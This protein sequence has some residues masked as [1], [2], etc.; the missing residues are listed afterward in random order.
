MTEHAHTAESLYQREAFSRYGVSFTPDWREAVKTVVDD[1]LCCA[2]TGP[3]LAVMFVA[4]AWSD[5]YQEIVALVRE[6]TGT[7]CL[8]GCSS[9]GVIGGGS[10]HE[11]APGITLMGMW[12]PGATLHPVRLQDHPDDWPWGDAVQPVD[13]R[14]IMMFTDPYRADAQGTLMGLREQVPGTPIVGSQAST[15]RKD[16]RVWLFLDDN[17]Y[18]DGAV[19]L[20]FEGP[21]ELLVTVSQGGTPIGETWTVTESEHNRILSISN[22]PALDVMHETL[23]DITTRGLGEGDLLVGFPMDEYQ[24]TFERDDF[25][26]RGI[27]GTGTGSGSIMVGCVP[28]CGQTIQFLERNPGDATGDLRAKLAALQQL[29]REIIGGILCTCKGRGTHMF[30]RNDHDA[31][32]VAEALPDVPM[33]GLYSLG[34]IGA[35]RG[36]PALNAFACSL[37]LILKDPTT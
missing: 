12:L 21:Y 34:E 6:L 10:C 31:K 9:S 26:A 27:L 5:D 2:S 22:R 8:I 30:G 3:D 35:V 4:T 36:V 14:G 7:R 13:V 28:R 15:N 18:A 1:V 20:A 25:V 17:V 37:G 11:S 19:G 23:D 29:D 32:A 24:Q 16:R 33:I